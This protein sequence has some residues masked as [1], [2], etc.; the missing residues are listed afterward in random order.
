[1]LASSADGFVFQVKR[2]IQN[3]TLGRSGLL[4]NLA[5]GASQITPCV[6]ICTN[7]LAPL[8]LTPDNLALTLATPEVYSK[9]L[10]PHAG[11]PA[12][13]S[14]L[15]SNVPDN[16]NQ[17]DFGTVSLYITRLIEVNVEDL[18]E[19]PAMLEAWSKIDTEMN[20][21]KFSGLPHGLWTMLARRDPI[22]DQESSALKPPNKQNNTYGNFQDL[23]VM[24]RNKGGIQSFW[25]KGDMMRIAKIVKPDLICTPVDNS[26]GR[27]KKRPN[28]TNAYAKLIFDC[29]T[30]N[31]RI[32]TSFQE[33]SAENSSTFS[34]ALGTAFAISRLD[35]NGNFN[36]E[37][38]RIFRG[39]VES[40]EHVMN[41]F[42]QFGMDVFDSSYCDWLTAQGKALYLP[43][44]TKCQSLGEL[45]KYLSINFDDNKDE[46][47]IL[48]LWEEHYEADQKPLQ[49]DCQCVACGAEDQHEQYMRAYVNHLLKCNEMLANILLGSHNLRQF[50]LF[51]SHLGK[52]FE[53]ETN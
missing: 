45:S 9:R 22:Y 21:G 3:G 29:E 10:W 35:K 16:K 15:F 52:L 6:L 41:L 46:F 27:G 19:A 44:V 39:K 11:D 17:I 34:S 2:I 49:F 26:I 1:M 14:T 7:H 24:C 12:F 36:P 37:K 40:L 43:R 20:V 4:V 33:L 31:R 18:L 5:T 23:Q 50:C 51:V 38:L 48:D 42:T 32:I 8:H 28:L 25:V 53:I 30:D 13:V 47:A